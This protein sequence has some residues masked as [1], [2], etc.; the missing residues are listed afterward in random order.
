[1]TNKLFKLLEKKSVLLLDGATGTNLFAMGLQSGDSPEFW[2]VDHADRIAKHY[3][4]FIEAGS[5]V[6]L[7]NTFGGTAYRLK[8]HDGQDRVAEL[9]IAAA[10]ILSEEVEKSGRE[11]VIAGSM[12]PTGEILEPA[13]TVSIEQ[14]QAAFSEQALALK[15][16]GVDVLW[17]ETISSIEESHA[18]IRGASV[19]G[20][21][22]V[23]TLSIDTNGRTMMGV[24][25]ADLVN[26][27]K[28]LEVPLIAFG[29]N[30]GVGAAEVIAAIMNMSKT[31]EENGMQPVLVAKGNCGIP[32][33]KSGAIS[34]SG[35]PQLMATYATM[36][37]DSGARIIG[38]CC[39]TTPAHVASMRAAIDQHTKGQ[40]P[41]IED[42]IK[43]LGSVT[44]GAQAQLGGDQSV[45][46]GAV[47]KG[48]RAGRT[49]RR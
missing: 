1:M 47:S 19:A 17:I 22:I 36:A 33:W 49:R 25:A 12:G 29:T 5:D 35:T 15:E 42:V 41:R 8:L 18:A 27:Q 38:G 26:L 31:A 7:T 48:R 13:G 39:G 10:R 37:M 45:E 46:G 40:T 30:C 43:I 14:A 24:T 20:L 23:L 44:A 3:R 34:Y 11:V 6:V 32:E 28:E 9:N 4:S 16:G 21:P 2:N